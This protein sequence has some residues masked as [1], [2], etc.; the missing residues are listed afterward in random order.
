MAVLFAIVLLLAVLL[1]CVVLAMRQHNDSEV[2][3]ETAN[4]KANGHFSII[5]FTKSY[6]IRKRQNSANKEL[7]KK[8]NKDRVYQPTTLEMTDKSAENDDEDDVEFR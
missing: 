3:G 8:K 2:D 5:S 6:Q 1:F 7:I 4:G